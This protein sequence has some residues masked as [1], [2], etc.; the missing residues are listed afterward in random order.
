MNMTRSCIIINLP[1]LMK[2]TEA[3]DSTKSKEFVEP[4]AE[5]IF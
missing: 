1:R 5:I 4:G 3:G 2:I